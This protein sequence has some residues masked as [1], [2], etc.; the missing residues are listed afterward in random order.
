MPMG[1][2]IDKVNRLSMPPQLTTA[3]GT[4]VLSTIDPV[5]GKRVEKTITTWCHSK[6]YFKIRGRDKHSSKDIEPAYEHEPNDVSSPM[7]KSDKTS[8]TVRKVAADLSRFTDA[9]RAVVMKLLGD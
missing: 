8:A 9:E 6:T 1:Y 3:T 7:T 4:T 2:I 5:T